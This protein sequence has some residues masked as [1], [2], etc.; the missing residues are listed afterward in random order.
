MWCASRAINTHVLARANRAETGKV[1][2]VRGA[3]IEDF[4]DEVTHCPN[5]AHDFLGND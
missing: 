2:L 5:S 1:V 3:W 4:L